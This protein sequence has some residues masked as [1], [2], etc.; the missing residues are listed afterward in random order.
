MSHA[1]TLPASVRC[2]VRPTAV[3]RGLQLVLLLGAFLVLGLLCGERAQASEPI[4][5]AAQVASVEEPA[6]DPL[7]ETPADPRDE[8]TEPIR[9]AT[10][11]VGEVTESVGE[12]TEPGHEATRPVR[13]SATEPIREASVREGAEPVRDLAV[14]ARDV[15]APVGDVTRPVREVAKPVGEIT[16]PVREAAQPVRNIA[17]PVREVTAPVREAVGSLQEPVRQLTQPVADG[18]ARTADAVT[19]LLEPVRL[20]Q[21]QLP[22]VPLPAVPG[23][24][25]DDKGQDPSAASV[26][27]GEAETPG[28]D[29]TGRPAPAGGATGHATGA[30][31]HPVA[32]LPHPDA[33]SGPTHLPA[34]GM[35]QGLC[36][37]SAAESGTQRPGDAQHATLPDRHLG[38]PLSGGKGASSA[39]D[40]IR[41]RHRDILEFPG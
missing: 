41:D 3:R 25:G 10:R 37:H 35:P 11:P 27:V 8:T 6:T 20:P 5:P 14:P 12:V 36:A 30:S 38:V 23:E 13:E 7:G 18:V 15:A 4:A 16:E 1:A 26:P 31:A 9:E 40:R 29:S 32:Q 33:P 39:Y 34:P 17:A 21:P 19:G 22:Y 28:R 2:L 24:R